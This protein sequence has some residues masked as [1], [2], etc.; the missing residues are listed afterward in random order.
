MKLTDYELV[1]SNIMPC[2]FFIEGD[3]AEKYYVD[4]QT[5]DYYNFKTE[6]DYDKKFWKIML[7]KPFDI[8]K[9]TKENIKECKWLV[10]DCYHNYIGDTS[11]D[12]TDYEKYEWDFKNH[13]IKIN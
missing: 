7:Y 11:D 12:N 5:C 10:E 6:N 2:Y 13:R 9:L 4:E 1:I 8:K 3:K